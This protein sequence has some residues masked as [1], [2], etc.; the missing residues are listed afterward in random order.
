M[1]SGLFP[2]TTL[3][4]SD[5][6]IETGQLIEKHSRKS[7][8]QMLKFAIVFFFTIINIWNPGRFLMM[9]Y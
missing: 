7:T 6:A 2:I 8:S 5:L 1:K 4:R 3:V 9:A